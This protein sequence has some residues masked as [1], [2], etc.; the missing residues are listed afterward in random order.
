V[1]QPPVATVG[2]VGRPVGTDPSQEHTVQTTI[3]TTITTTSSPAPVPAADAAVD[4]AGP[5]AHPPRPVRPGT[6]LLAPSGRR[7]TV[8]AVHP[9][10][11][12]ELVA[13][14]PG[15]PVGMIVDEVAATRMIAIEPPP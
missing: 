15:G 5:G 9:Q 1:L 4:A 13:D 2:L 11:R 6:E 12:V 14:G 10:Q 7:W 3:T 8:R